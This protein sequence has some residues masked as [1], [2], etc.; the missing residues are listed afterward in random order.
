[1]FIS[2]Q[3]SSYI[4]FN[5]QNIFLKNI[6]LWILFWFKYI[7]WQDSVHNKISSCHRLFNRLIIL[8]ANEARSCAGAWP[9]VTCTAARSCAGAW[10]SVTCTAARS[11]AG[12]WPSVTCTATRSCAGAWPSIT[13]LQPDHVQ[14]LDPPSPHCSQIMCRCLT[15]YHLHCSQIMCRCLT[16]RRLHR[17]IQDWR[18]SMVLIVNW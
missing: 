13:S 11:C 3:Y 17:S 4:L 7:R 18:A 10:P 16:L 2:T 12:A 1:M 14:V 9:S 8:G 6:E 5:N 15:L